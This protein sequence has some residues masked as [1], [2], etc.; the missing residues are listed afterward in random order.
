MSIS[1]GGAQRVLSE[2]PQNKIWKEHSVFR[3]KELISILTNYPSANV[4][5][6]NTAYLVQPKM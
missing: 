1:Q 2:C 5:D 6:L 4:H 3:E